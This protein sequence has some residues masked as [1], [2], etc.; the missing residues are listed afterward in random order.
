MVN[1]KGWNSTSLRIVAE[2]TKKHDEA[3]R[4]RR[5]PKRRRRR[6]RSMPS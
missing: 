5:K 2:Q 3:E 1:D 6:K 4:R